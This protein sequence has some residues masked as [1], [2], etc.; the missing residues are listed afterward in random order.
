M[1][2]AGYEVKVVPYDCAAQ[3]TGGIFEERRRAMRYYGDLIAD[4]LAAGSPPMVEVDR[5]EW[6]KYQRLGF[7]ENAAKWALDKLGGAYKSL[8]YHVR[9]DSFSA[10]YHIKARLTIE[11]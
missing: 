8:G 2:V 9:N 10:S 11:L 4:A 7:S 1:V 6:G 3:A 5:D